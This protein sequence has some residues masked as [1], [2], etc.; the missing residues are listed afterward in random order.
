GVALNLQIDVESGMYRGGIPAA[1]IDRIA[2][3]A[4]TIGSLPG[5][6]FDG[7]TT[8]RSYFFEGKRSRRE[9]GHAEG[10]LI[11]G[12]PRRSAPGASR[13]ARSTPAA[14]SPASSWRR[15]RGSPSPARAPTSSTTSCT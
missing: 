9:E 1:E 14:P 12:S 8:H 5:V 7:L 15:C 3:L 6:E 13:S 10:E 4:R 11:V 2:A